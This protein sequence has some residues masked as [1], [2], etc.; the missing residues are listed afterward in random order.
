MTQY[1]AFLRGINVGGHRKIKM[2]DLKKVHHAIGHENVITYLQSGNVIFQSPQP[3]NR[4]DLVTTLET[5][6][7][8]AF[9]F[10]TDV[11]LRTPDELQNIVGNNPIALEEG[12]EEKFL[13]AVMLSAVPQSENIST[14]NTYDGE[15]EVQLIDNNLYIYYTNGSARS[16]LTLT[17]IEKTL[18]VKGTARNWNTI[19]NLIRLSK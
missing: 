7:Q 4:L 11:I 5:S 14:F 10:T 18:K 17:F 2:E 8:E 13:H 1:I 16:K 6:Y 12:K 3:I 15:E 9:G 19:N